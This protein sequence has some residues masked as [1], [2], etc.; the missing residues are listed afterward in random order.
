[1]HTA[2]WIRCRRPRKRAPPLENE[3]GC[4]GAA[5]G[6]KR[7]EIGIFGWGF[8][9]NGGGDPQLCCARPPKLRDLMPSRAELPHAWCYL[10]TLE[11][12][13]FGHFYRTECFKTR[14]DHNTYPI[15]PS[16]YL[17]FVPNG[18][19]W[20]GYEIP[21]A[22]VWAIIWPRWCK[23]KLV[24]RALYLLYIISVDIGTTPAK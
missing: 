23:M 16:K 7:G 13:W 8:G 24:F 14:V 9:P 22:P 11:N 10:L 15:Q 6:V 1:M 19:V 20:R 4:R 2:T 21:N 18:P 5:T 3:K 17:F 12:C